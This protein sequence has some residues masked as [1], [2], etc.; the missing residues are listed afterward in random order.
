VDEQILR[1]TELH[2]ADAVGRLMEFWGFK[3]PMGRIWALL[4]LA[5][6]P[7]GALA[8]AERLKMSASAVGLTLGELL[9][10]GVVHKAWRPGERRYFF[11]AETSIFKLVRRVLREREL[12]L[13]REVAAAIESAEK[14]LPRR[15]RGA[16]QL[17]FKRERLGRLLAIARLGEGLIAALA[18]GAT[19]DPAPILRAV[20]ESE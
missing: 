20:S 19:V 12:V 4:Y 13:V 7:L 17:A 9:E 6:D 8:L 15:G 3:R 10:W 16:E 11:T 1:Q 5:P 18:A 2:V 14:A